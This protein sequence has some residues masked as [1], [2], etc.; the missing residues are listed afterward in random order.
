MFCS[1]FDESL[2]ILQTVVNLKFMGISAKEEYPFVSSEDL[3]KLSKILNLDPN[4]LLCEDIPKHVDNYCSRIKRYLKILGYSL[5]I[6]KIDGLFCELTKKSLFLF[7]SAYNDALAK[8]SSN[9]VANNQEL[10]SCY[11]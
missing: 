3:P 4:S 6:A 1:N 2:P 10:V 11:H 8:F 5:P 7:H 9:N